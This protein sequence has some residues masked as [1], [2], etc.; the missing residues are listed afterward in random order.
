MSS[1]SIWEDRSTAR[2]RSR[3]GGAAALVAVAVAL[4][5]CPMPP[6]KGPGQ[7][8]SSA[9]TLHLG[10]A[11]LPLDIGIDQGTSQ[12]TVRRAPRSAA[13]LLVAEANDAESGIGSVAL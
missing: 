7:V 8:D 13:I 5:S 12:A 4:P 1:S 6:T 11:G 9:P 2:E 10:S 3:Q